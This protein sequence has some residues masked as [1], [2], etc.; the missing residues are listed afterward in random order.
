MRKHWLATA[1]PTPAARLGGQGERV[2]MPV[3]ALEPRAE[4][5]EQWSA[6]PP[7]VTSSGARRIL[8]RCPKCSRRHSRAPGAATKADPEHR[9]V[10]IAEAAHQVGNG[11]RRDRPLIGQRSACRRGRSG[12]RGRDARRQGTVLP[13]SKQFHVSAP[14][15][16]PGQSCPSGVFSM[17]STTAIRTTLPRER[18]TRRHLLDRD[19]ISRGWRLVD[20][21]PRCRAT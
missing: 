2:D 14:S 4:V 10:G 8:W 3:E 1:S 12:R 17:F 6:A 13:G 5:A 15:P 21:H 19:G 9:F 20:S 16:A 18:M 7:A 11:G